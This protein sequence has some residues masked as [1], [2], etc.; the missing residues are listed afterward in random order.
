MAED[1]IGHW[2]SKDRFAAKRLHALAAD[3][4]GPKR[5]IIEEQSA[6]RAL[7]NVSPF[8]IPNALIDFVASH[9]SPGL[10]EFKFHKKRIVFTKDMVRKVFGIRCGDRLVVQKKGEHPE[11]RQMYIEEGQSRPFIQHAVKL[12]KACDVTDDLTII[13]T[14]DL[15][16]LATVIDPGSANLLSLD[17]LD[18][19]LDPRRTHEFAWDEH[20]L[21][22]A[23]QEVT[24]INSKT[25]EVVV[26]GNARKHEFWITGPFALLA[27]VYMDHLDFPP[28][29]HVINYSIPRV[30]FVT[31]SDF[32]FVVQND[33]DRK[34]L[35]NKTVFGR[36]PFLDLSNTPYGVAAFFNRHHVE[37]PVEQPVE[38]SEVN[39]SASLNEWLVFPTSQDL[40]VPAAYKHLYEKHRSIYGRDVDTTLKN[41]GVGLKQMHSQR[42]AA[43]LIDI[44]AAM[45]EGDGPSVHFPTGGGVEDENMDGADEREDE[46]TAN[47][48]DEEIPEADSEGT[49]NDEF[50]VEASAADMG[51]HTLVVDMPQSAVL[52]DSSTGGFVAGEQVAVDSPV[53]SP[54]NSPF[55]RIP[56]GISVEAWNRAPDPPSMDLFSQDP[57]VVVVSEQHITIPAEEITLPADV[58]SIVKLDDTPSEQPKAMEATTPPIPS[59]DAKDHLGENVSPQH[60]TN[61]GENVTVI[62]RARLV[63][64]DG[65]LSLIADVVTKDASTGAKTVEKKTRHK[66]AAKGELSPPKLKKIKVSQDVVRKYD[67]YVSHGRKFKRKKKNEVA[68]EFLKIGRFFCSYKSFNG[69]LRPRQYLSNAVMAIWT[70][71]FNHAAKA[72][73][74]KNPRNHKRYSF[75]PYFAEKL[76]VETSTFDHAS[77]MKEFKLACSKFKVLKDD[78]FSNFVRTA[79]E[80]KVSW[81]DFGKFK[82]ITPDHPQQNTLFD[83]GF[84]CILY[85]E[86]FNGKVMPTF[87]NDAIPDFRRVLAASLIDNRDNQSEDVDLIMNEDLQQG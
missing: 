38:E 78:M 4:D 63:A 34:I 29:Q 30:C 31:S 46:G 22:L 59:R 39:P 26:P 73:A 47:E 20:L 77:V 3:L 69:S 12:L 49:D 27:V 21:E 18:C 28:N 67:K 62:K 70:E 36:R 51:T 44:D 40:E 8:N 48:A 11:L 24:K 80:S 60:L 33:A 74:E 14:W 32:K 9:T 53:R 16:C 2:V 87:E 23:M 1:G 50:V 84:Y 10:R 83:C 81:V 25:A 37:E 85:M 68:K 56:E 17:Y 52:L 55:S 6:F 15:L 58:A 86:H 72:S 54:M 64:A 71:K 35:N 57:D 65:K 66:R 75:S 13:R 76:A 5:R 42:M 45:K 43:L 82:Q 61:T 7:L 41:F 79:N 19:M